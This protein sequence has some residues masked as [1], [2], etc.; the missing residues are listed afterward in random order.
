M[1][2]GT[3]PLSKPRKG[4]TQASPVY[5]LTSLNPGVPESYPGSRTTFSFSSSVSCNLSSSSAFPFFSWQRQFRKITGQLH[6][7]TSLS[8]PQLEWGY[9]FLVRIRWWCFLLS[10]ARG[11]GQGRSCLITSDSNL[12]LDHLVKSVSDGFHHCKVTISPLQLINILRKLLWSCTNICFSSNLQ[13]W[14]QRPLVDLVATT[15][16]ARAEQQITPGIRGKQL[17]NHPFT[18][19]SLFNQ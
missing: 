3:I 9:A 6:C 1:N 12:N 4:S 11:A 15:A 18:F 5:L 2:T 13:C 8:F 14:F 7:Q 17:M 19:K 16:V 10:V